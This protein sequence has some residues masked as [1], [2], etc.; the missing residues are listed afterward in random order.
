MPTT[1]DNNEHIF[2]DF[3]SDIGTERDRN[4]LQEQRYNNLMVKTSRYN[5]IYDGAETRLN[6][7]INGDLNL[8]IKSLHSQGCQT[9]LILPLQEILR[10]KH[11][12]SDI[13]NYCDSY[14][15]ERSIL[16]A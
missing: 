12:D 15:R 10:R 3:S 2:M 13:D 16:T 11:S 6:V 8:W 1:L 14:C 7:F 4:D 9:D 5:I